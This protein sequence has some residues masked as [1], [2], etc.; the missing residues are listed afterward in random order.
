VGIV[1]TGGVLLV[2]SV[3][4]DLRTAAFGLTSLGRRYAR[5]P[6]LTAGP[7]EGVDADRVT[8][9]HLDD[10]RSW[11]Q[12]VVEYRRGGTRFLYDRIRPAAV[13]EAGQLPV[14]ATDEPRVVDALRR[15]SPDW[16]VV[17]L[18]GSGDRTWT[19]LDAPLTV[20]LPAAAVPQLV[21]LA[22]QLQED[23]SPRPEAR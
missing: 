8:A 10:L 23:S 18:R 11:A 16:F 17:L 12:V 6:A 15:E 1:E 22:V 20:G 13:R 7:G 3:A 21:H 9:T 4:A 2:G 5:W 14:V 19:R